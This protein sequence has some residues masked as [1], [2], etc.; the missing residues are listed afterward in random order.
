MAVIF[1]I[2]YSV[3]FLAYLKN[4]KIVNQQN[5]IYLIQHDIADLDKI[6]GPK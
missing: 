1:N 2:K 5:Q 6:H 4:L 3:L